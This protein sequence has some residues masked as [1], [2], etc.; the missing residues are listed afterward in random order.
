MVSNILT[1]LF[2][3]YGMDSTVVTS[4]RDA[5]EALEAGSIDLLCFAYE[6]IDMNGVDMYVRARA[7]K[8]VHHQPAVLFA[9][10]HEKAVIDR[11]IEAGVTECF[12]K[13]QFARFE[14]FVEN[15]TSNRHALQ[16]SRV[17]LVEDSPSAALYYSHIM[18]DMGL[19]V[20]VCDSAD[21]AILRFDAGHYDLVMTDYVLAGTETGF[22][23]IRAVRA[24][25]GRKGDTPI[26]VISAFNDT[27]RKVELLRNGANDFISKPV[28]ADELQVR[29]TNLIT[30]RKLMRRLESQHESMRV[31]AMHDQLTSLYNRYYLEIKAASLIDA[32]HADGS[33]LALAVVDLD[34]FKRI[35]DNHGHKAGDRVLETAASAMRRV[36]RSSD[37]IAR[38]GG[39]EFVVVMPGIR[40]AEATERAEQIRLEI[41]IE[42]P[43]AVPVT[44]SIGVA[45]LSSGESY[46]DIFRRA[47][48]AAYRAKADGRN[49]VVTAQ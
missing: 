27:A 14:Q 35:N 18:T 40:L 13:R 33:D 11:A 22:A 24:T 6:L 49:R 9:A 8:L 15:F 31:M 44:A 30:M 12:S 34:H 4:G 19:A 39:E 43:A 46:D 3:R 20:D 45:T 5:L 36:V 7:R 2:A 29:I 37:V 47:D 17:L 48:A 23:V 26:L 38:V 21:A 32:A 25:P 41:G 16:G 42:R 1:E 28:I 10:T